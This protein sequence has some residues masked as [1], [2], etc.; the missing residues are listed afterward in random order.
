MG[1]RDVSGSGKKIYSAVFG[2]KECLKYPFGEH[3]TFEERELGLVLLE[4]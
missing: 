1:E 2:S 3:A 4:V